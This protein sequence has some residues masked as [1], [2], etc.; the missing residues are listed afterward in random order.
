M[1]IQD[2]IKKILIY[3]IPLSAL[4]M[5]G[6]HVYLHQ[7]SN[8]I[9]Q[10]TTLESSASNKII[11]DKNIYKRYLLL[12]RTGLSPTLSDKSK[13]S[14]NAS[15]EANNLSDQNDDIAKIRAIKLEKDLSDQRIQ[16]METNATNTLRDRI[17][18]VNYELFKA[19]NLTPEE[20]TELLDILI[21]RQEE[22]HFIYSK[23][24]EAPSEDEYKKA[25]KGVIEEYGLKAKQILDT[26]EFKIYQ[27]YSDT[28]NERDQC[29]K[30]LSNS[31]VRLDE[32]QQRDLI[33]AMHEAV[34]EIDLEWVGVHYFV[35][36][37]AFNKGEL[38]ERAINNL[39]SI[40][41]AYINASKNRLSP[42]QA[43]LFA[44]YI[45]ENHDKTVRLI[46]RQ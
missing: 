19:L 29:M 2:P 8:N 7:T 17:F 46:L 23:W 9:A 5:I 45:K 39:D 18:E 36:V 41:Q 26:D 34:K 40:D 20:L 42:S 10:E 3:L 11:T 13:A 30:F 22:F 16:G 6:L 4:V 28:G 31:D 1:G 43:E 35:T 44:A 12:K 33:E 14:S 24:K 15:N 27:Q 21:V 37:S 25:Y 32:S 38:N